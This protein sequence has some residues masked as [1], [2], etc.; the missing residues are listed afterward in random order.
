MTMTVSH[1]PDIRSG[2]TAMAGFDIG[3]ICL[4][5]T[6]A[7]LPGNVQHARSYSFPVIYEAVSVDDPW[8]VMRGEPALLP[9]ILAAA[10]TL[11][12]RGVRAICGACGSFGFYQREIAAAL[13]VPVFLS[14][15]MLVPLILAGLAPDRRIGIVAG[16]AA[17]IDQR[18]FDACGVADPTRL[19]MAPMA[20]CSEFANMVAGRPLDVAL[21]RAQLGEVVD[22][23]VRR[24][25]ALGA[26]LLQCSDL[27]PFAA[28]LQAV[29]GLPIFDMTRMIAWVAGAVAYQ[30]Y[31]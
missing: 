22:Q 16:S 21:L 18:L 20:D 3:I 25:P 9:P 6:H 10:R 26:I 15:L 17:L 13:D 4:E 23:L 19:A 12:R 5:T 11:R 24:E 27:P 2:G 7:L 1:G 30:P 29:T 28:D 31:R 8:R 14:P